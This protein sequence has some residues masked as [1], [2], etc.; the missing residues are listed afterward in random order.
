MPWEGARQGGRCE[1]A[2]RRQAR[3]P[4]GAESG[5]GWADAVSGKGCLIFLYSGFAKLRVAELLVEL[6]R[7]A[8]PHVLQ[9]LA[10]FEVA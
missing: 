7:F 9:N 10:L 8:E 4:G 3:A 5:R 6:D 1:G 2:G